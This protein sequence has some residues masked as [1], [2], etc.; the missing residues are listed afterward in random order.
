MPIFVRVFWWGWRSLYSGRVWDWL[1]KSSRECRK[2]TNRCSR[3][4]LHNF[5]QFLG[6][7]RNLRWKLPWW[8]KFSCLSD[9]FEIFVTQPGRSLLIGE[10]LIKNI[11]KYVI[12][13]KKLPVQI[14]SWVFQ[15][16]KSRTKRSNFNRVK[17]QPRAKREA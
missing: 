4:E 11:Q 2:W 13:S 6:H 1:D 17:Q 7:I 3:V 8:L 5:S 12:W 15:S 10:W 9:H 16:Q 14:S